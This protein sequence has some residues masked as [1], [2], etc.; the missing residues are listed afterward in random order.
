M[1]RGRGGHPGAVIVF[2]SAVFLAAPANADPS[3]APAGSPAGTAPVAA[4]AGEVV[5]GSLLLSVDGTLSET[6]ARDLAGI[7]ELSVFAD[8]AALEAFLAEARQRLANSRLFDRIEVSSAPLAVEHGGLPESGPAPVEVSIELVESGTFIIVP[9]LGFPSSGGIELKCSTIRYDLAGRAGTLSL[10][11]S[12]SMGRSWID[13]VAFGAAWLQSFPF[14]GLDWLFEAKGEAE[15][16]FEGA[17]SSAAWS[18]EA[19]LS[20]RALRL[21]E[22][23]PRELSLHPR[24]STSFDAGTPGSRVEFGIM[25]GAELRQG[26]VD[27]IANRRRGFQATL[28]VDCG[29]PT[30]WRDSG[31][32]TRL[33]V[34]A[35]LFRTLGERWEAMGRLSTLWSSTGA[36]FDGHDMRGVADAAAASGA[37][38]LVELDLLRDLGPFPFSEWLGIE[39]ISFLDVESHAGPF[40]EAALT[41]GPD[42]RFDP[43]AGPYTV[44]LSLQSYALHARPFYLYASAG[45][46]LIALAGGAGF[47]GA[48]ANGASALEIVMGVG[49]R[50]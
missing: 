33:A 37:A 36:A 30:G 4:R 48:G 13:G 1:I 21:F 2:A 43:V 44:G 12:Y 34:R 10:D 41:L 45:W 24:A 27:W 18:A 9:G 22:G 20:A 14:A 47:I 28:S 39:W 49:T 31:P 23:Q 16:L 17:I 5:V 15:A 25:I 40:V 46:D 11:Y 38:F 3:G 42:G 26:R 50:Y 19:R 32:I 6:I 35:A 7:E 29:L 8:A